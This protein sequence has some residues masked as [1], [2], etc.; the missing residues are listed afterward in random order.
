[1]ETVYKKLD[2]MEIFSSKE[3]LQPENYSNEDIKEK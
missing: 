2:D 3:K 1:M